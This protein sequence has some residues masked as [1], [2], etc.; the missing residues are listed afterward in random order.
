MLLA[1]KCRPDTRRRRLA[2]YSEA[3]GL[4]ADQTCALTSRIALS[5]PQIVVLHN[6][7]RVRD[8]R[9]RLEL[10]VVDDDIDVLR[11]VLDT[12]D[13]DLLDERDQ[14][15]HEH[16]GK[17]AVEALSLGTERANPDLTG[18]RDA[19]PE[20]LERRDESVSRLVVGDPVDQ[21]LELFLQLR[22]VL[23]PLVVLGEQ[24]LPIVVDRRRLAVRAL[25][26]DV[27]GLVQQSLEE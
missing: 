22:G 10:D 9:R 13:W 16:I 7:D 5:K 12:R 18:R 21:R 27:A 8:E 15:G 23:L 6:P 11:L 24:G 25:R 26:R 17:V 20:V 1:V 4:S 14:A 19:R 3:S 2:S